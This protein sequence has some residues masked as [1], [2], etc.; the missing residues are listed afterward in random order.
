VKAHTRRKR[1]RR[2]RRLNVGHMLVLNNPPA[3]VKAKEVRREETHSFVSSSLRPSPGC[4][5]VAY[6]TRAF[7][8]VV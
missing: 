3:L 4:T 5:A 6:F 8:A 1:R 7:S 2:R